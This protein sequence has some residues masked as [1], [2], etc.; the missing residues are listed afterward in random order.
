M[1]PAHAIERVVGSGQAIHHACL[2]G[3]D[4][5]ANRKPATLERSMRLPRHLSPCSCPSTDT[6]LAPLLIEVLLVTVI[7][8]FRL[9]T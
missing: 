8:S 4:G 7:D 1:S 6:P 2:P 5:T 9:G 3:G